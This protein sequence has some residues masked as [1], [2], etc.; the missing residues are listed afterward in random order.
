MGGKKIWVVILIIKFLFFSSS[1]SF[2]SSDSDYSEKN[3]FKP[4]KDHLNAIPEK[5][6]SGKNYVKKKEKEFEGVDA[7]TR[8]LKFDYNFENSGIS[9]QKSLLS[10]KYKKLEKVKIT[11]LIKVKYLRFMRAFPNHN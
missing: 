3:S 6:N 1:S 7:F 9:K 10:D 4:N 5:I 11:F 2:L 8:N